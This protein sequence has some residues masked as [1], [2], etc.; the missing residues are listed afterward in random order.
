MQTM[1]KSGKLF[2]N[3]LPKQLRH[4]CMRNKNILCSIIVVSVCALTIYFIGV[5]AWC[6]ANL[7]PMTGYISAKTYHPASY[8]VFYDTPWLYVLAIDSDDG[9]QSC[10]W[11][12]NETVYNRYSI[13]D[14]VERNVIKIMLMDVEQEGE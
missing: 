14:R 4:I 13:G 2:T 3:A 10:T 8:P 6:G 5:V 9:T 12:V 11:V 1:V 7:P